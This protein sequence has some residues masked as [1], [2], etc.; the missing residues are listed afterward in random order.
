QNFK[1]AIELDP[2]YASAYNGL[3]AAYRHAGNI[4]GAIFCW[5]KALELNPDLG[6]ALYNLGSAYLA[7]GNKTQALIYLTEY[8]EKNYGSLPSKEKDKLDALIQKCRRK[9]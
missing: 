9:S 3:G 2:D 8:K 6:F 4:N 1:K 7:T 5:E